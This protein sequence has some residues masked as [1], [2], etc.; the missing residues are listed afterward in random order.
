M[1]N[2]LITS[3]VEDDEM[4]TIKNC[5]CGNGQKAIYFCFEPKSDCLKD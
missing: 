4:D 5:N 2:I 3:K 1:N